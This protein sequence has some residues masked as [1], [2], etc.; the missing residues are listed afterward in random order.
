MLLYRRG[1][2]TD[3][4]F[5]AVRCNC[6]PLVTVYTREPDYSSLIFQPGSACTRVFSFRC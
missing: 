6:T 4:I 5:N 2:F 1:S 3:P